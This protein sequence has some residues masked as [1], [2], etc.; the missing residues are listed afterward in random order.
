MF[1]PVAFARDGA[2]FAAIAPVTTLSHG[3]GILPNTPPSSPRRCS[4]LVLV[5]VLGALLLGHD[6]ELA[7]K[8][9]V[10]VQREQ[11]DAALG[12]G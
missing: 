8:H 12:A 2:A 4:V 3:K 10:R 9:D 1:D 5:S 7:A 11:R 6:G